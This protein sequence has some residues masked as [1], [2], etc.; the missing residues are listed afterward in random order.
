MLAGAG[1]KGGVVNY[2]NTNVHNNLIV[3]HSKE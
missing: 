1:N 3:K 2:T